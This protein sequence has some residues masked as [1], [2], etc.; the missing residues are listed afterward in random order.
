MIIAV[1]NA[2]P[3]PENSSITMRHVEFL[4]N[5][6]TEH[7]FI[8][9]P[10]SLKIRAIEHN[11][12]FFHDIMETVRSCDI[13]LWAFPVYF[14]SVPGQLKRFIELVYE[15]EAEVNFSGKY[16]TA[17][18]TSGGVYDYPALE[19][20][21]AVCDDLGMEYFPGCSFKSLYHKDLLQKD[22]REVFYT[23]FK[24]LLIC[25]ED[26]VRQIRKYPPVSA[27]SV[28][29][30]AVEKQIKTTYTTVKKLLV[31]TDQTK[32]SNLE[33]MTEYALAGTSFQTEVVNIL[34]IDL[35]CGCTGCVQ[36]QFHGECIIRDD[37]NELFG[38]R[39]LD[40][41][42]VLFAFSMKG[43]HISARWKMLIDRTLFIAKKNVY[44]NIHAAFIVSGP[45]MEGRFVHE[46]IQIYAGSRCF[47]DAGTVSDESGDNDEIC[48][49][50][51]SMM[52]NLETSVSEKIR[53]PYLFHRRAYHMAMRELMYIYGLGSHTAEF[54]KKNGLFDYP[55]GSL[56]H[57]FTRILMRFLFTCPLTKAHF[58]KNI[59]RISADQYRKVVA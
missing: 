52:Q 49:N 30:T 19:Y 15:N 41:D 36:C 27:H 50:L 28:Q 22:V 31:L 16:S 37:V 1:L 25:T 2:S 58:R 26:R 38:K 48:K 35:R 40:S 34:D 21:H 39:I 3:K 5:N 13:V 54:Y 10:V 29:F 44:R 57:L 59:N 55:Q 18:A 6:F 46:F 17:I 43:R 47:H 53:R 33:R 23:F 56:R 14:Y 51:D 20:I 42:A 9:I 32:G 7:Q 4:K 8:D 11:L 12:S 24:R 45:A